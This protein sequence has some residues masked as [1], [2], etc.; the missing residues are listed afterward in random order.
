MVCIASGPSLSEEQIRLTRAARERDACR[1]IAINDNYLI[2]PWADL[3]YFADAHWYHWHAEGLAKS[4]PWARFTAQDV[5]AAWAAFEGQRVTIEHPGAIDRP[6]VLVLKKQGSEGFQDD[7][8][9]VTTGRNGGYQALQIAVKAGGNPIAL[10][11]YD[12]KRGRTTHAHNGHPR[13]AQDSDFRT[14]LHRFT[15][16]QRPIE[17]LGVRVVNCSRDTALN[18]FEKVDLASVLAAKT[19][20]L[21]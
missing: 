5:R 10:L 19:A 21:V 8:R 11:G 2:A 1:V 9:G 17:A 12:M 18:A 3:C 16:I 15:S 6:D 14:F 13:G 7:P 4:W 20:A